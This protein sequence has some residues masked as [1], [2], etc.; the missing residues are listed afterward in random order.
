MEHQ[1]QNRR[2][3]LLFPISPTRVLFET[4]R[5]LAIQTWTALFLVLNGLFLF[6]LPLIQRNWSFKHGLFVIV[7][8]LPFSR[9]VEIGYAFYNDTFDQLRQVP[10]RTKLDRVQRFKLLGCSYVEVAICYASLY[11]S[12]PWGRF[13]TL[14]SSGFDALYFSWITITTTGYGDIL[15][16]GTPTR[17][18]CMTEIGMGLMLLVFAVGTYFTF[19]DRRIQDDGRAASGPSRP[20]VRDGAE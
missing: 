15:P 8:L 14:F 18:L 17:L 7:W 13:N 4:F 5:F 3:W 1:V 9:I 10:I 20:A 12:L 2:K 19:E 16:L 11:L 6:F